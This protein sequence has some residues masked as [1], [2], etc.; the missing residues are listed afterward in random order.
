MRKSNGTG[1]LAAMLSLA[2]VQ[3][4]ADEGLRYRKGTGDAVVVP[5]TI[6]GGGP[7]AFLLDTGAAIT[8]VDER[9]AKELS[10]APLGTLEVVTMAG[11]RPLVRS[12]IGRL[13]IGPRVI[14]GV[15]VLTGSGLDLPEVGVPIRGVLG[16]SALARISYGI[17]YRRGRIVF[18]EPA[19]PRVERVP[20]AW[21]EGRP[22]AI[23][24]GQGTR[25]FALVL[26]S[27]LDRPVLFE[28]AGRPVPYPDVRGLRYAAATSAGNVDLRAVSVPG[29]ELGLVRL[30]GFTAAVV[31]DALAGGRQE[32]G[33]LPTRLFSSVYFDRGAGEVVLEPR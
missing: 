26:D 9:L 16:Q 31:A 5:V 21:R 3:A 32:D 12:R 18:T 10:L 24:R 29:L 11:R 20:L 6:D 27:G 15:D 28:K 17:D 22:A 13:A 23:V 30:D 14:D 8:R 2:A 4:A 1:W 25:S 19:G 33:L 7:H